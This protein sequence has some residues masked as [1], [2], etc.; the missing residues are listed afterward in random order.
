M[1]LV[2]LVL[3]ALPPGP[4]AAQGTEPLTLADET[5]APAP[6]DSLLR[7]PRLSPL[8]D[9]HYQGA[10]LFA[11]PQVFQRPRRA[12]FDQRFRIVYAA[13]LEPGMRVADLRADTDAFTALVARAVGAQGLVYAVV[14]SPQR[15]ADL[16]AFAKVYRVDNIIP[17][18]DTGEP[19]QLPAEGV[20][21]AFLAPSDQ[22]LEQPRAILDSIH[23]ALIP[24]GSLIV[25]GDRLGS[26]DSPAWSPHRVR[27]QRDGVID[28]VQQ[29]GFRLVD[30]PHLLADSYVLRFEKLSDEPNV[31]VGPIESAAPGTAP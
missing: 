16:Q 26:N 28:E 6:A 23:K 15:V 13:R 27:A 21:L 12:L 24:F 30:A 7:D 1:T 20:D 9:R 11:R 10:K 31:E 25:I 29:A 8:L 22:D 18:I 14:A 5:A 4:A 3:N 19:I 17:I 2:S